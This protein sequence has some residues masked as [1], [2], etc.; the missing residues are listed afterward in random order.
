MKSKHR[1]R[2]LRQIG[3]YF[4]VRKKKMAVESVT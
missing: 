3:K 2:M 4:T 1:K